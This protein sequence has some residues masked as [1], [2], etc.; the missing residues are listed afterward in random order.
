MN[1]EQQLIENYFL[2]LAD[3]QQSL[4]LK[5]DAAFLKDKN[6]VISTDMMIEGQHFTKKH[7]PE[8]LAKKLLRINLSDIAAMGADP[9]GFLLNVAIPNLN[10]DNWL[11]SFVKGLKDDMKKFKLK[12]FGGDMS[13]S[14]KVF[15]SVTILGKTK[16]YSHL[17]NFTKTNSDI[18]VTGNIGDAGL[19]L[20]IDQ[21]MSYF[22]CSKICRQRLINKHL[23][24]SPRLE[25]GKILLNKVEFCTDISDGLVEELSIISKRSKK[26][27]NI[28]LE[29]IPISSYAKEILIK[30]KQKE[31]WETILFG[32]E[33]FELLFSL[34]PN[35]NL[36]R[37]GEKITKIGC[38]SDGSGVRIYDSNGNEFITKKK[39]FSHF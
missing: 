35:K 6:L 2:P 30:N 8:I 27:V 32:G 12:L 18:Y 20:K 26:R 1:K 5:N 16:K 15:L 38:F 19:G 13:C 33:D 14:Q 37:N 23:L 25:I 3:N 17:K 34:Q 31:V 24:P 29:N 21:K 39:G 36:K 10:H 22:N 9:L 11:K 28:F 4:N 7:S